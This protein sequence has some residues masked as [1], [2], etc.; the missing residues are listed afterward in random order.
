MFFV[1]VVEHKIIPGPTDGIF[2]ILKLCDFC[3]NNIVNTSLYLKFS[4]IN[5]LMDSF[6]SSVRDVLDL[7]FWPPSYC[8]C[9]LNNRNTDLPRS[10][11]HLW[12]G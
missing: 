9:I 6:E 12:E 11:K 1:I 4:Y 3:D 8:T 2:W 5:N 7:I 10:N